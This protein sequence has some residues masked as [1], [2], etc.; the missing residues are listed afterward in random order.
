VLVNQAVG[1]ERVMMQHERAEMQRLG[2]E[3]QTLKTRLIQSEVARD[4]HRRAMLG[5]ANRYQAAENERLFVK[6]ELDKCKEELNVASA[7]HQADIDRLKMNFTF[8]DARLT[9]CRKR[10]A[11]KEKELQEATEL[12]NNLLD[13]GVSSHVE[14]S[15]KLGEGSGAERQHS[16]KRPRSSFDS[17]NDLEA[18]PAKRVAM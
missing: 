1:A 6:A 12:I 14:P 8:T 17:V 5:G 16:G 2:V 11:V 18:P 4:E 9:A 13:A 15:P 3:N 10:V 7:R